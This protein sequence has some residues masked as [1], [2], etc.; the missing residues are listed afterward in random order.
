MTDV[1]KRYFE[2]FNT[3]D[4][5]G[6]LECVSEDVAHHVNE[7]TV[8][9]GRAAFAEFC[10]HMARCYRE[11]LTDVVVFSTPDGKRAAAEYTVNGTY[12]HTDEGLPEATGQT[13]KLPAGSFFDIT[14]GLISRV[15]TRYNLSDWIRQVS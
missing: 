13:Y 3:G 14:D 8:R 12:V 11:N 15:T 10:G 5:P 1:V 9:H 7:G 2:A 4:L 6:M